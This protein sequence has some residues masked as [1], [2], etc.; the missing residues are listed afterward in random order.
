MY[1]KYHVI[2]YEYELAP[3]WLVLSALVILVLSWDIG[4]IGSLLITAIVCLV[5]VIRAAPSL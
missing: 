1:L 4:L 2:L 5:R 3:L